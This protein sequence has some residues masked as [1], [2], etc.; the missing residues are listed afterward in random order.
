MHRGDAERFCGRRNLGRAESENQ[1]AHN[2]GHCNGEI[3]MRSHH[4]CARLHNQAIRGRENDHVDKR[5]HERQPG[6]TGEFS[7]LNQRPIVVERDTE[8]I[9]AKPGENPAA[10]PF[11]GGPRR[12]ED[13]S[14]SQIARRFCPRRLR[15]RRRASGSNE[16]L[17]PFACGS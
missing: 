8:A 9:P 5:N 14:E 6:N 15:G 11:K 16:H 3:K 12:R 2:G 10:Q 17:A 7:E 4:A 1:N 13:E